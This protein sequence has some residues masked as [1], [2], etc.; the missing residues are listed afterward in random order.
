MTGSPGAASA[1]PAP[2]WLNRPRTLT[3]AV[4]VELVSRIVRGV[5]PAG[6]SLPPE[7][8][9]AETFGVSRTVVR[10]AMKLL[11]AKGLVQVRQGS[12]TVVNPS[13]TWDMLDE[14]VL[15]STIAENDGLSVLDDLVVTRR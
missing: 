9:L 8:V 12:G 15:S 5:H 10:E 3:R 6:S 11:E 4:T 13:T 1:L 2:A 7:P 14:L